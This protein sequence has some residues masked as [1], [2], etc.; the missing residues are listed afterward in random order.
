M[1]IET[2]RNTTMNIDGSIKRLDT[3][4]VWVFGTREELDKFEK[5]VISKN[6]GDADAGVRESHDVEGKLYSD[7]FNMDWDE[8]HAFKKDV[9][10][11]FKK[12][13]KKK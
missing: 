3:T 6:W 7:F 11:E 4:T 5:F 9:Y 10:M 12:T 2:S 8:V 1:K 13:L